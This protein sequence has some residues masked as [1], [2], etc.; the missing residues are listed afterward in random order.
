ME[1]QAAWLAIFFLP[2]RISL[3]FKAVSLHFFLN[4]EKDADIKSE[5][6]Y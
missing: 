4:I 6:N 1:L 3:P 2:N 5:R